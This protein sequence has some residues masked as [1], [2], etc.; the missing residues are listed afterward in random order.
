MGVSCYNKPDTHM[1]LYTRYELWVDGVKMHEVEIV[2][3][4]AAVSTH[5]ERKHS[6]LVKL[7]NIARTLKEQ[8]WQIFEIK[9][10]N[11]SKPNIG[12]H[13]KMLNL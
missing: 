7:K 8:E 13:R 2:Y 6:A 1:T 12:K 10:A 11:F 9:K 4:S 3:Q 5:A